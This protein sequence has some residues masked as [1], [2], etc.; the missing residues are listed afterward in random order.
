MLAVRRRLVT[1]GRLRARLGVGQPAKSRHPPLS[2][3]ALEEL[4]EEPAL[5]SSACLA[6]P[7]K[8]DP[9]PDV[10]A[11]GCNTPRN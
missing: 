8:V 5:S 9:P 10:R 2:Q 4:A 3:T 7:A 6:W 1:G 11:V